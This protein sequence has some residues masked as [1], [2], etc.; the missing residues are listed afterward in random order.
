MRQAGWDNWTTS[1]NDQ[2]MA[3]TVT[4]IDRAIRD[5]FILLEALDRR[6]LAG[7]AT[8]LTTAQYH[9][10]AALAVVPTQSLGELA[11]RRLCDKANVSGLVDKLV[12]AGLVHRARDP[13]DGRRV[14]LSLTGEGHKLL[15]R[16]T[17]ARTEA[18]LHALAPLEA[19]GLT[20]AGEHLTR[21]VALL[22]VAVQEEW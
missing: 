7:V 9:T 15:A 13:A 6:T 4:Q 16:A 11:E 14:A 21:L 17:H 10:L 19:P 5:A 1:A 8:R 20:T 18:L 2:D 12:D 22:R 3:A